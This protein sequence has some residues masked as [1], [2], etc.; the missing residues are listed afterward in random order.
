MYHIIYI[1]VCV[2]TK[3]FLLDKVLRKK[4][5]KKR[6]GKIGKQTKWNGNTEY[7]IEKSEQ[8]R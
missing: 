4:N 6:H 2:C 5:N 1:C 8:T 3:A 7:E